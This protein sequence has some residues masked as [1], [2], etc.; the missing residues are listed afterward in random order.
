[1]KGVRTIDIIEDDDILGSRGKIHIMKYHSLAVTRAPKNTRVLAKSKTIREDGKEIE[2][3]EAL[4]YPD[5]S[6][7]IQG[8][9]EE[10]I[11][12]NVFQNFLERAISNLTDSPK[13]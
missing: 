10:G 1:M 5:G 2:I 8:H 13:R 7:S 12:N 3:I 6:I 9:P 4:R 11:A